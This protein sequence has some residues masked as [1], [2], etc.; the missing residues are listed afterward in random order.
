MGEGL[1]WV[2]MAVMGTGVHLHTREIQQAMLWLDLH[3]AGVHAEMC[4]VKFDWFGAPQPVATPKVPVELPEVGA[5]VAP[6]MPRVE[7]IQKDE[8]P[9]VV[10]APVAVKPGKVW[11]EGE[12]GGVV[13]VLEGEAPLQGRARELLIRMLASVGISDEELA[14]VGFSGG[15]AASEMSGAVQALAAKRVL[16]LGQNPLG[17]LLG[18]KLGVEG[19][20]A[21]P[22]EVP[23][24]AAVGV[25]YPPALL[26]A[27]PLFKRLA[28]QHLL[29]WKMGWTA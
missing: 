3:A 18:K 1:Y 25:T 10:A 8:A 5:V 15:I 13:V 4:E 11:H 29:A 27:Q 23:G 20:Q 24:C 19:W 6:L 7:K 26:L 12:P 16:V 21:A 14:W 9:R 22:C 28:W 2:S 17:A